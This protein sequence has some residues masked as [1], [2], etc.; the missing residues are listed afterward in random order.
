[1]HCI[2]IIDDDPDNAEIVKELTAAG[3]TVTISHDGEAGVLLAKTLLPAVII[4]EVCMPDFSGFEVGH[5]LKSC[6]RTK[7]IPVVF[8]TGLRRN[9]DRIRAFKAGGAATLSKPIDIPDLLDMVKACEEP[10]MY[11]PHCDCCPL[12]NNCDSTPCSS[13]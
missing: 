3:M 13:G 10:I 11:P 7:N 4:L 6:Q 1:M 9:A 8:L 12:G 5:A 2:L